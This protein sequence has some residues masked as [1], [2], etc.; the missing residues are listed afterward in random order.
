ME[1]GV[2]YDAPPTHRDAHRGPRGGG[3]PLPRGQH[4]KRT[5]VGKRWGPGRIAKK[6]E[7]PAAKS[8]LEHVSV[9]TVLALRSQH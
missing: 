7:T 6:N 5:L 1:E 3:Q 4:A 8:E 9:G 2:G